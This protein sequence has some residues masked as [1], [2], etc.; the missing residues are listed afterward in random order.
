MDQP[1]ITSAP[2]VIEGVKLYTLANDN[3]MVV[4]IFNYGGIV[5]SVTFPD[6]EGRPGNVALGFGTLADYVAHNPAPYPGHETGA[7]LYFGALIGRYANRIARGEFPLGNRAFKVPLNNGPNALHGGTKGFDQ[8]VWAAETS[9]TAG[10]VSLELSH[11][12][13]DGEMG[14]PGTLHTRATYSLDN[15]NRLSL[16]FLAT[17]TAETVI[18]LTNHTYWNLR[19]E[20]SGPVYDQLLELN[21]DSFTPVDATLIP[22]GTIEAVAGT[23]FDFTKPTAIGERIRGGPQYR[24]ADNEQLT[25]CQGYDH[26]FVI[27]QTS[28]PSLVL[29]ARAF[30]PTSGREL[31]VFTTEPGLQFYSGNFL[32]AALSGTG[33]RAY[34]QSDG[35]ALEPQHFPDSPNN[36]HF[37]STVLSPGQSF[38]STTIYK[39]SNSGP[40][41]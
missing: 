14:F 32:N 34:R 3:G 30:D 1:T 4:R 28:P 15:D 11:V 21:A 38:T 16:S 18:N 33:G 5:Q 24:V 22:T 23:P 13:L 17:T 37:P 36:D 20:S 10:S 2:S 31:S 39:M 12:S 25:R 35:F 19:G 9:T 8:V 26:N 40:S 27:N 6:R 7:G 29:A 41:H